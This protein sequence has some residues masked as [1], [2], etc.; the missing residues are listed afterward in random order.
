M[1][2]RDKEASL[3][4]LNYELFIGRG[5][6]GMRFLRVSAYLGVISQLPQITTAVHPL[7]TA[8]LKNKAAANQRWQ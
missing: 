7:L 3:L 4:R 8:P 2:Q 1:H 5:G 6:G